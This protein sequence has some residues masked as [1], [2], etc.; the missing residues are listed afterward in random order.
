MVKQNLQGCVCMPKLS[1]IVPVFN[2]EKLLKPCIQCLLE[3]SYDNLEVIFVNDGSTDKSLKILEDAAEKLKN[4]K[5]FS[6]EQNKSLFLARITGL[7][8]STGDYIAFLDADDFVD[9]NFYEK[10]IEKM[11][12]TG[13]DMCVTDY[14]RRFLKKGQEIN[15]NIRMSLEGFSPKKE[16]FFEFVCRQN[17]VSFDMPLWNHIISRDLYEK[18]RQDL[19]EIAIKAEGLLMGED[20]VYCA[21]FNAKANNVVA[22]H[23]VKYHYCMHNEQ[24]IQFQNKAKFLK[25]FESS[26]RSY[27]LVCEFLKKHNLIEKYSGQL[28]LW[29]K[30]YSRDFHLHAIRLKCLKEYFDLMKKYNISE[31]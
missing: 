31:K 28:E 3:Q 5:I 1:I 8:V 17:N 30:I 2:A 16:S 23:D 29:K 24:S 26:L 4:A 20:N 21:V 15:F 25:Q 13:A 19:E 22:E 6:H 10:V 18:C 7:H 27:E 12:D 11:L 14:V 9:K